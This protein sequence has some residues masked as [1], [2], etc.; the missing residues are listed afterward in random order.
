MNV[1]T[2]MRELVG[3]RT[4]YHP[5]AEETAKL[6]PSIARLVLEPPSLRTRSAVTRWRP[7][8]L[9]AHS[10]LIVEVAFR[11][12]SQAAIKVSCSLK[13]DGK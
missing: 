12:C 3:A 11:I 10:R 5:R 4:G 8:D 13:G 2:P 6:P 9:A 1:T 7:L